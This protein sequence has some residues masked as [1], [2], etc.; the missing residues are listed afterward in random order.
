M[1]TSRRSFLLASA[2]AGASGLWPGRSVAPR[3]PRRS[4]R[5]LSLGIVGVGGRGSENL[6][7][8]R[9]EDVVALCDVDRRHLD[10][11]AAKVPGAR[12]FADFR[13]LIAMPGLDGVVIS[14]PDHT[15]YPA[16]M[17]ALQRGLDVYCEKPLTHT[18]AQAR[19][20]AATATAN[21]CVTQMGTQIHALEN[22]RRVV[23]AVRAGAVGAIAEVHVFVN[24]ADWSAAG[25]P[26]DAA[27]P[28]WLD[29]D[30]WLG[31]CARRP[32][33]A[34]YHPAAW[35]R[36]WAFGGG[37]TADMACHYL[38]LAFWALELPAP[39]RLR[40]D[41]PEPDAEGA[42]PGMRCE[43]RF[44]AAGGRPGLRLCWWCGNRRPGAALTE[45]GLDDWRNGVL[46]V[47]ERGWLIS[48][49]TRFLVGPQD[50]FAGWRPPPPSIA[51]SP[52]HHA[53]W[54]QCCKARTL[55]SCHFGC[56]G[57]LTEAALLAN[58]AFRAARG[59]ELRWDAA[60]LRLDGAAGAAELLDEAARDGYPA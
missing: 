4:D 24:G 3:R 36:Y 17:L 41:G 33:S 46:F 25:R 45:R 40:A 55:P 31:P 56:A 22:Y 50:A 54:L 57:P 28:E 11:A 53:E 19:R 1:R 42:P 13:E 23:E 10:A 43:Y 34:A 58:V 9:G 5:K 6:D 44:P 7:G 37:T 48:D 35:R 26:P 38:D 52:G 47:G 21:G 12:R 14:T 16:A 60:A 59:T 8:V 29:W 18:V 49:Y 51:P 30:L 2:A 39:A 32:F 20:L 27:V 15:H